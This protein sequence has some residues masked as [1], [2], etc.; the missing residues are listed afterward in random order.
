M[1]ETVKRKRIRMS[2]LV[3]V[4]SGAAAALAVLALTAP[5]AGADAIR[6]ESMAGARLAVE[7]RDN[8][9]NPYDFGRNPAWLHLDYELRYIRFTGGLS[10]TKGDLRRTYDPHLINDLYIGVE[11]NKRLSDRQ[12]VTGYIDYRRLYDREVYRNLESDSYN[13]PFY[14]NDQ[15]TGDFEY[16]GPRAKVDWGMRLMED[17]WVGA[18]L[19]YDI[20]TGLKQK[21]T[22]PEI[23]HNYARGSFAMA[24]QPSGGRWALG[25][26]YRPGRLQNRTKFA[27][28]DEGYDNVIQG[29]SGDAIYEVRAFSSYTVMEVRIDH[30][31]DL[32]GFYMGDDLKAGL[33]LRGAT[34]ETEL[35]YNASRQYP[36]GY[37]K[38]D[39]IDAD[40]RLRWTPAGRPLAVGASARFVKNDG[41][42]VRP[43]FSEVLLYDN[44]YMMYSAGLGLSYW[45]SAADLLVTAE[46]T[47]EQYDIEVWDNGANLYRKADQLSQIARVGLEKRI[48]N[49]YAFRAGYEYTDYPIDRWIKLPRNIDTWRITGGV[50]AYY[51]GW[52]IDARVEYGL[53]TAEYTD[54]DRQ[55]MG[56]VVWVTRYIN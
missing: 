20:N 6:I 14:L 19:V 24:W 26:V 51:N 36:K 16:Y 42:G 34:S 10:E 3:T 41:W 53:G 11:G 55:K 25:A 9:L 23:I 45:I 56:A 1:E 22:R 52:N 32:Q 21:Y 17:M 13:D 37:W 39:L 27:K 43:E 30:T 31:V 48:L 4:V 2:R 44:P 7:D 33:N 47:A 18:G 35:K 54:L 8:Q 5:P 38:E 15:T 40:F 46:Y 49:V 29:Y 12:T 50:G 28:P